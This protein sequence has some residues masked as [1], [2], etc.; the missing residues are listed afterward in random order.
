MAA[1]WLR[2]AA[3]KRLPFTQRSAIRFAASATTSELVYRWLAADSLVM[4]CL[5]SSGPT[6]IS[7]VNGRL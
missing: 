2:Q 5:R 1:P 4:T 6:E 3:A 7:P